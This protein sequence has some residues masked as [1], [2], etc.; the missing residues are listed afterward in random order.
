[1]LTF[2]KLFS[3]KCMHSRGS[4]CTRLFIE[5]ACSY[6]LTTGFNFVYWYLTSKCLY[7]RSDGLIPHT[8]HRYCCNQLVL[9]LLHLVLHKLLYYF[10]SDLRVLYNSRYYFRCNIPAWHKS[11]HHFR[12]NVLVQNKFHYYF[13][14]DLLVLHNFN[15]Y[16]RCNVPVWHKSH[17]YLVCNVL[18]QHKSH[19]YT[20]SDLRVLH[21][22]HYY[23]LY[24][25]ASS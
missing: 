23:Y 24:G 16:F 22:L 6:C 14:C 20:R 1:M 3:I 15:Y 7:S 19:Y 11:H 21:N 10:R 2:I 25:Y 12:C 8:P 17:Y 13:R 18:V 5:T 9:H 4:T